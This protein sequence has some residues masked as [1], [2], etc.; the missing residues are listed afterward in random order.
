MSSGRQPK[1]KL[2][3]SLQRCLLI[4]VLQPPRPAQVQHPALPMAMS[5]ARQLQA[6]SSLD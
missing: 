6:S 1:Q 5:R 4:Q 2:K 3:K